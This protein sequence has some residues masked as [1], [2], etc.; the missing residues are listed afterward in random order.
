MT[1]QT[2]HADTWVIHQEKA[3][4]FRKHEQMWHEESRISVAEF[5]G[6]STALSSFSIP[7]TTV[8][9]NLDSKPEN[10]SVSG[11]L[12]WV[13]I[14]DSPLRLLK[15]MVTQTHQNQLKE[16]L[17]MGKKATVIATQFPEKFDSATRM[18]QMNIREIEHLE[19]WVHEQK[20]DLASSLPAARLIARLWA[21]PLASYQKLRLATATCCLLTLFVMDWSHTRH[22]RAHENQTSREIQNALQAGANQTTNIP[23]E[24]WATQMNK[25]GKGDRANLN[26]ISVHWNASGQ[27]HTF[28]QLDRER[29]R[30]PKGCQLSTPTQAI[31]LIN[32]V[33]P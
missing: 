23:F 30:V 3:L 8:Y 5:L 17:S 33:E 1:Q 32:R 14:K 24:Q 20:N 11:S 25:F 19:K 27:I 6:S 12:T 18:Q 22:Q 4:L 31:C 2:N 13:G 21:S 7:D 28:A 9:L 15:V 16:M 10:E 26:S 29:K